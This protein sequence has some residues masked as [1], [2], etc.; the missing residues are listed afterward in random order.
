[1]DAPEIRRDWKKAVR[2]KV[3]E[4]LRAAPSADQVRDIEK[5]WDALKNSYEGDSCDYQTAVK[6]WQLQDE[7]C[8]GAFQVN[9]LGEYAFALSLC[10]YNPDEIA[11]EI[12]RAEQEIK[13]TGDTRG[14]VEGF[15]I[16]T[17]RL[18]EDRY[19]FKCGVVFERDVEITVSIPQSHIDQWGDP[20]SWE[21]IIPSQ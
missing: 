10:S 15:A 1:M 14:Q 7:L 20:D 16:R 18:D 5:Q 4:A 13:D 2:K 8:A 17:T 12:S 21:V 3:V 11:E 9:T 6:F 19:E